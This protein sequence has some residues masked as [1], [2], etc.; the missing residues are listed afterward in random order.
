M[1]KLDEQLI[2]NL[3]KIL[4]VKPD[5]QL[6]PQPPK[7]DAHEFVALTKKAV[8]AMMATHEG[9]VTEAQDRLKEARA[10]GDKMIADVERR[11]RELSEHT[12][13][14]KQFAGK[15]L[16]VCKEFHEGEG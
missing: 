12:E 5:V 10:Y 11:S 8:E 6:P 1:N 15:A 7:Y 9:A 3:G 4:D 16:D 2:G 14:S 13:R